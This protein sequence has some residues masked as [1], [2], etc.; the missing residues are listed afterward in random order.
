LI[1]HHSDGEAASNEAARQP[2]PNGIAVANK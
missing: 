1:I 2:M